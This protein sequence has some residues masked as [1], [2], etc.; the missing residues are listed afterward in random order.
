MHLYGTFT[1][2]PHYYGTLFVI[3]CYLA[4]HIE[5]EL[6][7]ASNSC[8]A[9]NLLPFGVE[10]V[11]LPSL[12]RDDKGPKPTISPLQRVRLWAAV[13]NAKF[14]WTCGHFRCLL[15]K[16]FCALSAN[17][18]STH[19]V[20]FANYSL[21]IWL[22]HSDLRPFSIMSCERLHEI[23]F[24]YSLTLM[25]TFFFVTVLWLLSSMWAVRSL[26]A[27]ARKLTIF[28][29]SLV[30]VVDFLDTGWGLVLR[31]IVLCWL[32][33]IFERASRHFPVQITPNI[34]AW[35]VEAPLLISW[36][37]I[38]SFLTQR[39]VRKR[40]GERA[41]LSE[42]TM[43]EKTQSPKSLGSNKTDETLTS[44]KRAASLSR[45][46]ADHDLASSDYFNLLMYIPATLFWYAFC[47][48]SETPLL[49][50]PRV[51]SLL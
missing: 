31:T 50:D 20:L 51:L 28:G 1:Y 32:F 9:V 4:P 24:V 6:F 5:A 15:Y 34:M 49:V 10:N 22:L 42:E 13:T 43:E 7:A 45:V 46:Q 40:T 37:A 47:S 33:V 12:Q 39:T 21:L 30:G 8:E 41:T 44:S 36:V 26:L 11:R 35:F 3:P 17:S 16:I 14:I 38:A 19:W 23:P 27:I 25:A 18:Y 2:I 29:Y 48:Q